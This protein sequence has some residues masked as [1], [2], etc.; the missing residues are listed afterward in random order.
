MGVVAAAAIMAWTTLGRNAPEI[1]LSDAV[2]QPIDGAEELGLFL[3][4]TNEG[5]ANRLIRADL[6]DLGTATLNGP[7][8][9]VHCLAAGEGRLYSCA[10]DKT[11]KVWSLESLIPAGRLI[12]RAFCIRRCLR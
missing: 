10:W 4:I 1:V 7:G 3:K 8:D 11:I 5:E 12:V 6:G 2:I 9:W